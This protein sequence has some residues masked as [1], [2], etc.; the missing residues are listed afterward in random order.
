MDTQQ[1]NA[2]NT[3]NSQQPYMRIFETAKDAIAY[4]HL[5]T[6]KLG[7]VERRSMKQTITE[8]IENIDDVF[9]QAI[10]AA[11]K[12]HPNEERLDALLAFYRLV[13]EAMI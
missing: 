13:D 9:G 2:A 1:P 11:Y 4:R 3:D 10:D 6:I 5:L 8:C 12:D 7:C